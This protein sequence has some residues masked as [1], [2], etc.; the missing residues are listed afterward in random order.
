MGDNTENYGGGNYPGGNG[1]GNQNNRNN[2]PCGPSN[3]KP[4]R[5]QSLLMLLIACLMTLLFMSYFMKAI[6]GATS[7]EISYDEFVTM[8]ETGQVKSVYIDQDKLTI[9]PNIGK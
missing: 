9:T 7:K 4:P 1:S 8:V 3:G 6:N 5:K 2:A